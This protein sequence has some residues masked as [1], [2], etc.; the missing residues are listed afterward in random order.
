MKVL[1]NILK[2]K[3]QKKKKCFLLALQKNN[4]TSHASVEE[5][6]V[7]LLDDLN[8]S[9]QDQLLCDVLM[10]KFPITLEDKFDTLKKFKINRKVI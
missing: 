6:D 1:S 5:V 9:I 8:L 4:D 10:E 2:L 7:P 3:I